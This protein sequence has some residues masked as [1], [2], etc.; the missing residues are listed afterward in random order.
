MYITLKTLKFK[1]LKKNNYFC[2]IRILVLM[3]GTI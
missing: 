3:V 1:N 2:Y